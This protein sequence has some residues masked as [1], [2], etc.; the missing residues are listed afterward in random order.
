MK[1]AELA[2]RKELA[3]THLRIARNELVL[4]QLQ[5]PSSL[6]TADAALDLASLVLAQRGF[7]RWG[8]YARLGLRLAHVALG[9]RSLLGDRPRT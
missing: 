7:G 4:A 8:R 9:V 5:A 6:A 3:L 1:A 2:L